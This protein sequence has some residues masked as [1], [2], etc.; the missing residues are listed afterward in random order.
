[1]L[2]TQGHHQFLEVWAKIP[3]F[4]QQSGIKVNLVKAATTTDLEQKALTDLSLS[5]STYDVLTLPD[6]TTGSAA[7]KVASLEPF[8][9]KSGMTVDAFQAQYPEWATKADTF[10][11][12][13]KFTPF[14]SGGVAVAYRKKLFDDPANKTAFQSQFG[15]PLPTPPTT[16]QQFQDV[17]KFF[18]RSGHYGLVL[19]GTDTSDTIVEETMWR[20]G[21]PFTDQQGYSLWGSHYPQNQAIAT[22]AAQ[23]LQDLVHKYK[24]VPPSFTGMDTTGAGTYFTTNCDTAMY[25]DL[26]YLT[27]S[28]VGTSEAKC[29][30]LDSFALPSFASGGGSRTSYWM[31]AIPAASH[32]QDAAWKY[33]QWI[34]SVEN[35]VLAATGP[36]GTFVP[37]NLTAAA[38]TVAKGSVPAGVAEAVKQGLAY[39]VL[40]FTPAQYVPFDDYVDK[41]LHGAISGADFVT[42]SGNAIDKAR[43]G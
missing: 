14:Y 24:V 39:P 3:E 43:T 30:P 27:W 28:T 31:Y 41:L 6:L 38:Q 25:M 36:N 42:Q 26:L 1:V 10:D 16:P 7:P 20:A 22:H 37:T 17:A 9:K 11:G 21:L 4:E 35:V 29:G 2:D 32:H 5:T 19:P 18:T 23:F 34:S 12:Q 33:I 8:I 40:T 15:Y 13:V